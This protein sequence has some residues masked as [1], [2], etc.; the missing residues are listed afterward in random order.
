MRECERKSVN[1]DFPTAESLKC[2]TAVLTFVRTYHTIW[3]LSSV[4]GVWDREASAGGVYATV[5]L[6]ISAVEMVQSSLI[7]IWSPYMTTSSL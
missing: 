6:S 5:P 4:F 2:K 7:N 3:A 1:S